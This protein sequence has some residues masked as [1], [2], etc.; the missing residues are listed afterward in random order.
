MRTQVRCDA[1]D[2]PLVLP[3]A[4]Q[5]RTLAALG[6]LLHTRT[7]NAHSHNLKLS[8]GIARWGS[9][10]TIQYKANPLP[11]LLDQRQ[12]LLRAMDDWSPQNQH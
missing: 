6:A 2:H 3:R 9:E 1:L 8:V 10:A 7:E 5:T 12:L 11:L 4:A